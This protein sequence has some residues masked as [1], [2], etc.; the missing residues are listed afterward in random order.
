MS[1]TCGAH[2]RTGHGRRATKTEGNTKTEG[3]TNKE[4][5]TKTEGKTHP[6]KRTT[7]P[8]ALQR[9]TWALHLHLIHVSEPPTAL[10]NLLRRCQLICCVARELR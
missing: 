4:G 8:A 7:Y 1:E 2:P 5:K 10:P 6:T 3:K 9:S